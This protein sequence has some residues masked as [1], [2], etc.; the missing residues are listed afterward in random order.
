M[1]TISRFLEK[2]RAAFPQESET[3]Y[4]FPKLYIFVISD[5]F[6]GQ[7]EDVRR[8][9]VCKQCQISTADVDLLENVASIS[10]CIVTQEERRSIYGFVK[11]DFGGQHW[12][13]W[14]DVNKPR[15]R[16][17]VESSSR[18]AI[19]GGVPN[20]RSYEKSDKTSSDSLEKYSTLGTT[21]HGDQITQKR[22]RAIHFYGYK[23]GQARS[24]VLA[25]FAKSLADDGFRVLLVDVDIEA[26]SIDTLFNVYTENPANTLV[27]LAGWADVVTP[28][29]QVYSSAN[30][31]IDILPC[32][33]RGSDFDMDFAAFLT[34]T[35]LD[36]RL[37][38]TAA[39]KLL[40]RPNN[41]V[42]EPESDSET[43][44]NYDI[45]LFDHRT[46]LSSSVLPVIKGYPGSVVIFARPDGMVSSNFENNL[47]ETLLSNNPSNPGGFI[48]FS[49]DPK[50]IEEKYRKEDRAARFIDQQ[51][52]TFGSILAG[53]DASG[54]EGDPLDLQDFWITWFLDPEMAQ[55]GLP[56]VSRLLS[57]NQRALAQLRDILDIELPHRS[58][59]VPPPILTR[60]G[61]T[62]EGWFISTPQF[63]RLMALDSPILYI[64]GRKGTGKTRILTEL[65]QEGLG[66]PLL[67]AADSDD[68]GL[69]SG[70]AI[71]AALLSKVENDFDRFWWALLSL[72]LE[73][74]TTRDNSL[75]LYVRQKITEPEFSVTD[76]PLEVLQKA[77]A[78]GNNRIFL[79]DGVETA[80]PPAKIKSFVESLFSVMRVVQYER[81]VPITLR[82]FL[83][84]DLGKMA[85]QNIEQQIEGRVIH[86]RWDKQAIFNF[87][88]ARLATIGFF[89]KNFAD[90]CKEVDDN[91][92]RILK[93]ALSEE[94][95]ETILLKVFPERLQ[96]NKLRSTT[97]FSAYF[98]D[99]GGDAED[100]ASF[101]PRL[102]D[103]FLRLLAE[104]GDTAGVIVDER[105]SSRIVLETYDAA[106]EEFITEVQQELENLLELQDDVNSNRAAVSKFVKSFEG[107]STPFAL[108][109]IIGKIY[110]KTQ[111][112]QGAIR[113][114]LLSMMDLGIFEN[115]PGFPGHW[116]TGRIYK[117]GLRMRYIR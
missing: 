31:S 75:E 76:Q 53:D 91:R 103:R 46:G 41:E 58:L 69:R 82:L 64:F 78:S 100:K 37:L 24:T 25:M 84:S 1:I 94:H 108:E 102:F 12:M 44:F 97:F 6:S 45:V 62:D 21:P 28:I 95:C 117:S 99:A 63:S 43:T 85:S 87:A 83:R 113:R 73:V 17:D 74:P 101:Y 96:R 54:D 71:F 109:E 3:I 104:H 30:G 110:A 33:P 14:F 27:G 40:V 52:T 48:C 19:D 35:S 51:L 9:L 16:N 68:G 81:G 115:R 20:T 61:A 112:D 65:V 13:P 107:L 50:D 22:P 90:A 26:P 47:V 92:A 111:F 15:S 79:I 36:V 4:R 86:L 10:L 56:D 60:S 18:T 98:S 77:I 116:R 23:G 89:Q 105:L 88:V 70:Q 67:V 2:V 34:R 55:V 38:E 7:P 114:A 72:A 93:G 39:G 5:E 80:V 106:S 66:E 49:L 57:R 29:P 11:E 8:Y 32:R 59:K 42:D